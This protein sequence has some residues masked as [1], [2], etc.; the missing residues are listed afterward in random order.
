A[1]PDLGPGARGDFSHDLFQSRPWNLPALAELFPESIIELLPES[2][3]KLLH[4]SVTGICCL[5]LRLNMLPG[6]A[7][8]NLRDRHK[9][10]CPI[11][12][13]LICRTEV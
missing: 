12:S 2:I 3:A 6:A 10:H 9:G 7:A 11:L 8:W 4:E 5:A 13:K 1:T